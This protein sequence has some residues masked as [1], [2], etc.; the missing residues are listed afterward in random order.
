MG[1]G[2]RTFI[3]DGR[4]VAFE[5]RGDGPLVVMVHSIGVDH[6]FYAQVAQRLAE[7]H[8]VLTFDMR[9]HGASGLGAATRPGMDVLAGDLEDLLDHLEIRSAHLVG[10]SI[11]A[12]TLLAFGSRRPDWS[13]TLMVFDAVAYGGPEWDQQYATRATAVDRHGMAALS[14]EQVGRS[15]GWTTRALNTEAVD[16]YFDLLAQARP[17]GYAWA[18]RAMVGLD[19]RDDLPSVS[20]PVLVA[21]GEED[22]LTSPE[23]ARVI[24]R[25][26]PRSTLALVK[27]AGHVPCLEVPEL[28]S[29]IIREWIRSH[30]Q[31]AP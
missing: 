29:D 16:R 10:Q 25:L 23:Q 18:C 12:M 5:E 9:G 30:S 27:G 20:C 3:T 19:F 28:M 2:V 7:D 14:R 22:E 31:G 24:A 26:L 21:V 11:G 1:P 13:G 8:R 15:L 6:S 4:V 17:E